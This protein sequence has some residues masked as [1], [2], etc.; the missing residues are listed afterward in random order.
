MCKH[1]AS[2][3]V[4]GH[5]Y[6]GCGGTL[7]KQGNDIARSVFQAKAS[8]SRFFYGVGKLHQSKSFHRIFS[9]NEKRLVVKMVFHVFAALHFTE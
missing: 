3:R 4:I 7:T 9:C 6:C 5:G 2:G 1:L 8:P